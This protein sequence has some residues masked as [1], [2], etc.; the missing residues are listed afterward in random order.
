MVKPEE[1]W[2]EDHG[3]DSWDHV[4]TTYSRKNKH[5]SL[6]NKIRNR[7]P[8][9]EPVPSM[10]EIIK[11]A[12]RWFPAFNWDD[13]LKRRA[14]LVQ[15]YLQHFNNFV[16]V[17]YAYAVGRAF[18]LKEWR[19]SLFA[20]L[21][22]HKVWKYTE[23]D[24]FRHLCSILES[25]PELWAA[26]EPENYRFE[27]PHYQLRQLAVIHLCREL[28]PHQIKRFLGLLVRSKE[29][30]CISTDV[31]LYQNGFQF[32]AW[33][34]SCCAGVRN[35][36]AA[37]FNTFMRVFKHTHKI[38]TKV[39]GRFLKHLQHLG[40]RE[41]KLTVTDSH[42]WITTER[43]ELKFRLCKIVKTVDNWTPLRWNH[44]KDQLWI[45]KFGRVPGEKSVWDIPFHIVD[46]F[47]K[48]QFGF[49]VKEVNRYVPNKDEHT[50]LALANLI[51]WFGKDW[52][53]YVDQT[54]ETSIHDNGINLLAPFFEDGKVFLKRYSHRKAEAQLVVNNWELISQNGVNPLAKGGLDAALKML[55]TLYYENIEDLEF[56][57]EAGKWGLSQ[58][59]FERVQREWISKEQLTFESIPKISI[60]RGDWKFY[61]LD[62]DDPRGPFLGHYTGCCQHP[63]G[64]GAECARHGVTSPFGGFVVLEY[65]GTI[66]FQS[67][68]WRY[69]DCLV[70]DN[71]EG[72]CTATIEEE[73]KEMYILGL[74]EFT[75]KLGIKRIYVGTGGSDIN[76]NKEYAQEQ[77][78]FA[79][80]GYR[81]YLDSAWLWR[82]K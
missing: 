13:A 12:R 23:I 42:N 20:T 36:H 11:H 78:T 54:S 62:R 34:E 75:G 30:R 73:A 25:L 39:C 5:D 28:E 4:L 49:F 3:Y 16:L 70:A 6:I 53:S 80:D 1:N 21:R 47:S 67:W 32:G 40:D 60:S 26:D 35:T 43:G 55:S 81:G 64:A 19:L 79:P 65:R 38:N 18:D 61:K 82:I 74:K 57:I 27:R 46:S 52:Q 50:M 69:Q 59:D 10:T 56:S 14:M 41:L 72:G 17:E 29:A 76:L 15:N 24:N 45:T 22:L 2:L 51:H 48:K 7:V 31:Y 68:V 9:L 66:K 77:S 63:T 44:R 58:E 8:Q 33:L 71:I 37:Y